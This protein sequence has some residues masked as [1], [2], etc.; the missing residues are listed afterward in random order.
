MQKFGASIRYLTPLIAAGFKESGWN[1]RL[2][3][4]MFSSS[5]CLPQAR[6]IPLCLKPS[7]PRHHYPLFRFLPQLFNRARVVYLATNT[8]SNEAVMC[9]V[10]GIMARVAALGCWSPIQQQEVQVRLTHLKAQPAADQAW[11]A[12]P[13]RMLVACG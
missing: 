3:Y 9:R 5:C 7:F 11:R 8:E 13:R 6:S 12:V 1:N 10:Q 2:P 4:S